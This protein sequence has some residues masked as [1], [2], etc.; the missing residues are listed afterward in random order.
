MSFWTTMESAI[1][2]ALK[3]AEAEVAAIATKIKPLIEA[4]AEEVGQV[5]LQSVLSQATSVLS[6]Q[7][8]LSA[9]TSSVV[10]TLATQGK[11]VLASTAETAVQTAFN[12]IAAS[13]TPAKIP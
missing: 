8:K 12:M 2:A 5:A 3:A 11:A 7:E 4:S 1:S 10:S 6:G 13:L 9:A